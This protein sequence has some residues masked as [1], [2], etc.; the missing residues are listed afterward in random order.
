[1]NR[2]AARVAV[3]LAAFVAGLWAAQLTGL[4]A[5]LE[6]R[7]AEW[8]FPTPEVAP[9]GHERAGPTEAEDEREIYK[10]LV[11]GEYVRPG[12]RVVVFSSET[13][14]NSIYEDESEL[15]TYGRDASFQDFAAR[16]MP[17]ARADTIEDYLGKNR[18]PSK[19]ELIPGLG[20]E[21]TL[22][23]R[24]EERRIL[25]EQGVA[26]WKAF[27]ETYGDSP[28]I[29][30]FSRVG[31]NAARTQA[32]VYSERR[33]GSLCGEGSYVLLSK[34]EGEWIIQQRSGDWIS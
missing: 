14:R 4:L 5:P 29:V 3:A 23:T 16:T 7:L 17:D 20:Y 13:A 6:T 18:R 21:Q 9:P 28:G 25:G 32:L 31:F 19:F 33:C 15:R 1:M 11:L 10:L 24:E 22:I 27:H 2:R 26:G 34:H 12:V 8:L 30:A